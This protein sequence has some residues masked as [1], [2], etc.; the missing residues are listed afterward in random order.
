M[1]AAGFEPIRLTHGS[2]CLM[3]NVCQFLYKHALL[4]ER[5]CGPRINVTFR[6]KGTVEPA[7][8]PPLPALLEVPGEQGGREMFVG[9]A[10]DVDHRQDQGWKHTLYHPFETPFIDEAADVA[11]ARYQTWLCAQPVFKQWLS[12]QIS[13]QQLYVTDRKEVTHSQILNALAVA[14]TSGAFSSSRSRI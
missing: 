12:A 7:E 5:A 10:P 1:R 3:E 6:A 14:H 9:L 2:L 13:G 8:H 11:A 4:P